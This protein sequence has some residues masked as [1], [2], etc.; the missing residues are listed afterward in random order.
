MLQ[1]RP[2]TPTTKRYVI[3]YLEDVTDSFKYTREVLQ[4]LD[5]QLREEVERLG[6]NAKLTAL[7][8]Q[9]KVPDSSVGT[10]QCL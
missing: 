10:K 1:K 7:L 6:G 9:L 4:S 5:R 2:S 3:D 8:D